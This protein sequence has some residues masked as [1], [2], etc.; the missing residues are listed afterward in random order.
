MAVYTLHVIDA[1]GKN[2]RA[3]SAF[4]NFEWTP[5]VAADGRITYARWDYIDRPNG[6]Y[7]SLWSTNPDGTNPQL[8]YGNFTTR[9]HC[10]FEARPIPNSLKMIFTASAHHYQTGGSLVLLDPSRGTE[11]LAPITRLTPEVPFPEAEGR[12]QTWYANPWPLSETYYLTA[13]SSL[14]MRSEGGANA[15][16][17]LGLYL[18]DSFGNLELI[19]RDPDI[20]SMYPIPLR[21]RP[22]PPVHAGHGRR[23]GP[24]EGAFLLVDA[25][26]GLTGVERGSVKRL[27]I[28]GALPK[29]QP[30]MNRPNLGVTGQDPGKF[31][32]GTVPVEAD[33][34]AHF[35]VPSG[36]PVFFQ[37][38]DADGLA[39]RT[40]RTLTYVQPGQTLSC[41][42]CHDPRNTAPPVTAVPTAATRPPSKIA[43]GPEGSWPLRFD[44]LV[45]PVL[46][47]HCTRCHRPDGKDP[48]AAKLDLTVAKAYDSLM[49]SPKL[50]LARL[51]GERS[52]SRTGDCV[53][54]RSPLLPMLTGGEA[55]HDVRLS[56]D[57]VRRLVTWMD[58]YSQRQGSFGKAQEQR[59]R[60][61]RRRWAGLMAGDQSR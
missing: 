51:S 55:H 58:L 8:V 5:A 47:R 1:D 40:M 14:P 16:S 52:S 25:H 53:A 56:P 48:T 6:P 7:M 46:E 26:R 9:P 50:Q 27:R 60:D 11:G 10:I 17:A 13:W 3:I 38:L 43:A 4:E 36:V 61:L 29:T 19:Y 42:G 49:R 28:V 12:P 31:V 45:G 30:Q 20:C 24:S 18:L 41:V 33:G 59:L 57:D 23:D 54:R 21:S 2:I 35:R 15:A 22:R 32:L 34:S 37:A 44:T 39:I